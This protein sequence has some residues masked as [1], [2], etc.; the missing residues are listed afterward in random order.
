VF[1]YNAGTKPIHYVTLQPENKAFTVLA[2]PGVIFPGL[3]STLR[4][5]AHGI[6][7]GLISSSFQITAKEASWNTIELI[8]PVEA[9]FL[10]SN[11]PDC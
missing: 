9:T 3:K 1:Y 11:E 2:I 8:I 10:E 7:A 6:S 5:A 4:V